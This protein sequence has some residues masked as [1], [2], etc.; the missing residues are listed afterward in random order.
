M[1]HHQNLI[2]TL[3][4]YLFLQEGNL[5]GENFYKCVSMHVCMV[6]MCVRCVCVVCVWAH[7]CIIVCV[8]TY[9]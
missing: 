1:T 7:A 9:G 4:L 3:W 6:H 8:Y 5:A 2:T